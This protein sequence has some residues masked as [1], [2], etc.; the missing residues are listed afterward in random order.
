MKRRSS[1]QQL[2]RSLLPGGCRDGRDDVIEAVPPQFRLAIVDINLA[3]AG[4]ALRGADLRCA[5]MCLDVAADPER[6]GVT[7]DE[8]RMPIAP[9]RLKL[10]ARQVRSA[11]EAE[12]EFDHGITLAGGLGPGGVRV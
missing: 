5:R 2:E 4:G 12:D 8:W 10:V 11:S 3:A 6:V 9:V 7:E 1:S